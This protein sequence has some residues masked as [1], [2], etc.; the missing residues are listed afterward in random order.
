PAYD[1][2]ASDAPIY[3]DYAYDE[4]PGAQQDYLPNEFDGP[5][6]YDGLPLDAAPAVSAADF[7]GAP[8]P[9]AAPGFPGAPAAAGAAPAAIGAAAA[10]AGAAARAVAPNA[11]AFAGGAQGATP[12]PAQSAVRARLVD[13][14]SNRAYDLAAARVLIGRESKN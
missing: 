13:A 7:P 6:G 10:A 8:A 14:S 11:V 4:Q 5:L 9:A 3:D 1:P 2:L 12:V